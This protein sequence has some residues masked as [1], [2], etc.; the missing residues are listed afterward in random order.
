MTTH[1]SARLAWHDAGWNGCFCTNPEMNVSCT[2]HDHIRDSRDIDFEK[3]KAGEPLSD[4]KLENHLPCSRDPACFS[5]KGFVVLHHDPLEWRNLPLASEE[6]PA[7]SVCTSPYGRMFATDGSGWENDPEEQLVRLKDYWNRIERGK[8]LVFFYVNHG[9]PLKEEKD[10]ILVGIGRITN[11][12][13]QIFFGKKN[14]GDKDS[15]VWSRCITHNFPEE[16]LRLPYQEYLA[17]NHDTSPFVCVIPESAR[18]SF[19]YVSE[20]VSDDVAVGIVERAIHAVRTVSA[21]GKVQEPYGKIWEYRLEWLNG[22]LAEVW[23]DRG[24]FPGIGSVL[25]YLKFKDGLTFHRLFP[26]QHEDENIFKY[27]FDVLDDKA[28]PDKSYARRFAKASEKWK[29]ISKERRDLLKVLTHFELSPEQVRRI[30]DPTKRADALIDATEDEIIANPYIISEL[31]DG[32]GDESPRVDFDSID[33]GMFPS[34][35]VTDADGAIEPIDTEDRRRIR[36][37]LVDVLRESGKAGDT[38]LP[39]D[40]AFK[41]A[42]ER[43]P[44]NRKCE[45]DRDVFLHNRAFHGERMS[46]FPEDGEPKVIALKSVRAMEEVVRDRIQAM[47]VAK[48]DDAGEGFWSSIVNDNLKDV[49]LLKRDAEERARREKETALQILFS[50]RFS[51]LTGK[52]GT[53][54]T[55]ALRSFIKGLVQKEGKQPVLLLAPTGKARVRL[56]TKIGREAKTIHQF[57]MQAGWMRAETYTLLEKGGNKKGAQTVII[58]EASMIPIDLLATLFRAIDFNDVKRLVLVGDPNQLPPIGPGW[59]FVDIIKWLEASKSGA[60]HIAC[61]SQRVRHEDLISQARKLADAFIGEKASPG[62]DEILS[63]VAR[64]EVS[65]DLE[66]HFWKDNDDLQGILSSTFRE[67]LGFDMAKESDYEGFNMSIQNPDTWQMLSPTRMDFFG[68]TEI[69]RIIQDRFK[70]GLIENAKRKGPR[71]F[72][73]QQLVWSDKVIQIRNSRRSM[74][75]DKKKAKGYV[76]NGEVGSITKTSKKYKSLNVTYSTQPGREYIYYK[77]E[78]NENLELAYAITV[79]KAQGSDFDKV[80]LIIPQA[81]RTMSKELLYTG[82]TRFKQKMVLLIQGDISP[83][84]NY[85]KPQYSEILRR[86]TNLFELVVRPDTVGIPHVERLIHRTLTGELV[87]SKSEV[88]VSNLLT[89]SGISYKY[90]EPLYSKTDP[91]DFRLPD[92]TV[93]YEG[94]TYYWEHLG[95][96]GVPEYSQDWEKKEQWYKDNGYHEMLITSADGSDGSIDSKEIEKLV[97]E[98]ILETSS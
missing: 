25:E 57:L 28:Q 49:K 64:G 16:G 72:G 3:K 78:V 67:N 93:K 6:M 10:R 83:L 50:K 75:E 41:K 77:S 1:I 29:A 30:C 42:A 66:V 58:D 14:E 19:R 62:D 95:M 63:Q 24:R 87:R 90:E 38:C 39:I 71:P 34:E 68:T 13:S 81:A 98:R 5:E 32:G 23:R 22:L 92:F 86:N 61:L 37:L 96:L 55:T 73:D 65:G 35:E 11:V 8:S 21:Q 7:H 88:I 74:W 44:E 76:A 56:E 31:D 20:H 47:L 60:E 51:V 85:R 70:R 17:S 59:P 82:L 91:R 69:N 40:E 4:V 79:H 45:I 18:P 52:A 46:F 26:G 53:G 97:K 80:F 48:Y 84:I 27:V 43:L 9:N 89:E 12:A 33:R 36:A 54:K 15:P 2:V 94:K